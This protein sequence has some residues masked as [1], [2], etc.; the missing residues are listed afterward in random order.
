VKSDALSFWSDDG[1]PPPV[2]EP[3]VSVTRPRMTGLAGGG[4]GEP[5][6][7]AANIRDQHL[8]MWN[9]A[10]F[11]P[12]VEINIF[13]D[14]MVARMRD[15]VRNDGWASGAVTRILDNVVGPRLRPISKPDHRYLKQATGIKGFDHEWAKEFGRCLDT[16]WGAWAYGAGRW[17]DVM[18]NSTFP[19]LMRIAY[20]HKIIDGDCLA[21]I[22][23]M[24]ARV[25]PGRATYATTIELID[26]DRLSNP[27]NTFDIHTM[28]GGVRIDESGAAIGYYIRAAHQSDWFDLHG[29]VRWDLWPREDRWGRAIIIHDY[30][31][32][33]AQQHRGGI[34]IF[35]PVMMRLRMLIQYDK[36]EL[37]AAIINAIL[38]AYV[39]SPADPAIIQEAMQ[40]ES[41]SEQFLHGYQAQRAQFHRENGIMFGNSRIP[42]LFPGEAINTVNAARPSNNY[43]DFQR[44][45]LRNV[46][47]ACGLSTEQIS[48]DWSSTNY[49][50][51]RAALLEAWK[52]L[53]RSKTEFCDH[54]C[55]PIRSAWL[56]EVMDDDLR[57]IRGDKLPLPAGAPNFIDCRHGYNRCHWMGP[58]RGWV[59]PVAERQGA[60]LGMQAGLTT[61]EEECAQQGLD[62]EEVLEQRKYE[63]D[64]FKEYDMELPDWAG[65]KEEE[66]KLGGQ[67]GQMPEKPQRPGPKGSAGKKKGK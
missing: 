12:D 4:W 67:T 21:H 11:S 35:T 59:D 28:R 6:Y 7:D 24:P 2:H 9:P 52:T 32:D 29:S 53:E 1:A 25:S 41:G 60:V 31:G 58:G 10:L 17:C 54:F 65:V 57:K 15:L 16:Y 3:R 40:S 50:S 13:R 38:G 8:A 26:P 66:H 36:A 55:N 5:P 51:A 63:I 64:L 18:R 27:M 14:R 22:A 23:D 47:A 20:R 42:T 62:Y 49:S 45:V 44:A 39:E 34:G 56:E 37:D 48:G 19:Q 33:R 43:A 46:A 61:L 30:D